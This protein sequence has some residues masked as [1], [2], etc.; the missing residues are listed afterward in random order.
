MAT[1]LTPTRPVIL[2]VAPEDAPS[3]ALSPDQYAV[4]QVPSGDLAVEW[5]RDLRPDAIVVEAELADSTG[6]EVCR[7]LHADFRLG[8][9]VPI[10]L[11]GRHKPTSEQRAA[12]V[13]A[14]AWDHVRWPGD[15]R[16]LALLVRAYVHAK[17][18]IDVAL[19]EDLADPPTGVHTRCNCKTYPGARFL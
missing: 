9:N 19:A 12:A 10:L 1:E 4:M 16:E 13:S 8:H 14:G 6:L 2:V 17:R 15:S 7:R 3:L 5:A 18:N 11:V